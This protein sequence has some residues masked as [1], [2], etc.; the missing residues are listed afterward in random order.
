MFDGVPRLPRQYGHD[1][2]V[3]MLLRGN[4]TIVPDL[5]AIVPKVVAGTW[6]AYWTDDLDGVMV[7]SR[8]AIRHHRADLIGVSGVDITKPPPSRAERIQALLSQLRRS[9]ANTREVTSVSI[10]TSKGC[11]TWQR[12]IL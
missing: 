3:Q 2:A 5:A 9:Q 7:P 11:A 12:Q 10:S 8:W 4:L 6:Y 1:Q